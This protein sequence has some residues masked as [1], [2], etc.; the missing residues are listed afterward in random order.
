VL[1]NEQADLPDM[2]NPYVRTKAMLLTLG[3]PSQQI[4]MSN[5]SKPPESLQYSLQNIAVSLYAKMN[6]TPW[7]VHQDKGISDEL[8]IGMG[9]AELSGSRSD[10]RKRYVGITTV[11]SG[12]GTYV[13][14]NVSNECDYEN[15]PELV[16]EAMLS[17]LREVK[18][19]NNWRPGDTIRV[20]FHAHRPLKRIDVAKIVFECTREVGSEQDIQLAFVTVT[21]DHPFYLMDPKE[22]GVPVKYESNDMKGEW[23]PA[24]GT[25]ARLGRSTRLLSVNSGTLIKRPLTPLPRPLLISLHPDSTFKDVDYLAEQVLK[26]TSLS[27]RSTLPAGTPVTIF[28]SEKIAEL[29]GRMRAVPDWSGTALTV[30]LRYSRWFL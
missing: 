1:L 21:L 5:A 19:R 7:T 22:P 17:V 6:G 11:F 29:L 26:F 14:G 28:Y 2:I 8:V 18:K 23:A 9:F 27:W 10:A 4:K 25:I 30:K 12:D 3:I 20:V 15:Y 24:R 13:L 16:R